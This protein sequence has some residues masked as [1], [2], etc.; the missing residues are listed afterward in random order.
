LSK[1]DRVDFYGELGGFD[2]GIEGPVLAV[3]RRPISR[4]TRKPK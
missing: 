3:P 4:V 2:K 1:G